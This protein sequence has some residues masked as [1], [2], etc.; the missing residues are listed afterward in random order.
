MTPDQL[1]GENTMNAPW[2]LPAKLQ[3]VLMACRFFNAGSLTDS[4]RLI[5]KEVPQGGNPEPLTAVDFLKCL[6]TGN[7]FPK[8]PNGLR[9]M[10]LIDRMVSTGLLVRA[11][12]GN[13]SFAGMGDHYLYMPTKWDERRK[14]FRYAA[15]LGPE[16]LYHLFAQGLVHITGT[17][18]ECRDAAAGTGLVID[19]HHVLTCRHVVTEGK[20]AWQRR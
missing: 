19:P 3:L 17:V 1:F 12:Y 6:E 11:G 15:V 13:R 10:Q 7:A 5:G 14:H 18:G 16:F 2:V 4:Y 20:C 9:V 8:P